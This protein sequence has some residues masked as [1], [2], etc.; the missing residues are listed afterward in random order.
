[1]IL[2]IQPRGSVPSKRGTSNFILCVV[3]G[4]EDGGGEGEGVARLGSTG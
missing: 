4:V 1:M 3:A 2:K